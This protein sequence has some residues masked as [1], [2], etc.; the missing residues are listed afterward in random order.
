MYRT[1]MSQFHLVK[2]VTMLLI[3]Q[4]LISYQAKAQVLHTENFAVILDTSKKFKGSVIPDFK[5][6]NQKEDL[7]EFEN[8]ANISFRIKN[9]AF[10]IANKIELSKYGKNTLLSGGFLYLEYR[11][12]F[13]RKYV[14]EPFLQM[15]WTEARGLDYK[16]ASGINFRYRILSNDKLGLFVGTGPFYEFERWN[17]KGVKDNLLP[18]DLSDVENENVKLG[19]YVSFKWFTEHKF[20]FDLSVYHQSKIDEMF[21]TPRLASSSSVTYNFTNNIGLILRYQNIYDYKPLV[22][23]DKLY[24]KLI[25]TIEVAF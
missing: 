20:D 11:K 6:Q 4:A 21:S 13:R 17:Y 24:N 8:T 23:I 3:G 16:I 25:F 9:N 19:T 14:A 7:I 15:H 1:Q 12:I 5:Y 2:L 18:V 10:T 22:P